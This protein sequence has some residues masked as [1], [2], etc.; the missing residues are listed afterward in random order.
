[1]SR[2]EF[3]VRI[4]FEMVQQHARVNDHAIFRTCALYSSASFMGRKY[5]QVEPNA[6]G[7]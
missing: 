1:M 7:F 3:L 6:S 4:Y 2:M 5:I